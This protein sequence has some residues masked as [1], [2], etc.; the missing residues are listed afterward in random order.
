LSSLLLP[1]TLKI[2]IDK[3]QF[4]GTW[5]LNLCKEHSVAMLQNRVLRTIFAHKREKLREGW[6]KIRYMVLH[7]L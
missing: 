5:S 1:T 7:N 3:P 6:K 2:K 4:Y